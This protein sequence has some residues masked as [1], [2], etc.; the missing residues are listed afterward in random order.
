MYSRKKKGLVVMAS[1]A[2]T[3]SSIANSAFAYDKTYTVYMEG[4]AHIDTSWLWS[5]STTV[6][7]YVPDT[8]NKAVRL[9]DANSDYTFNSPAALHHLWTKQFYPDLFTK[10]KSKVSNGQWNLVGGQW[11]EPDLNMTSGESLVRQSLFGQRFFQKEFG[12]KSKVGWVPD[13]F[14]FSGQLPQILKKSGMDYFATTKLNWN[15]PNYFPYELFNWKGIDGTSLITYKPRVDYSSEV[16]IPEDIKYV[17]DAP[18]R[19]GIKK[20][21]LMY[22]DGDNGGGPDQTQIDIIHTYDKDPSMPSVKMWN[23]NSYFNNLTADDKSKITDTWDGEMYLENH[24]G[25]YTSQ[26][27]IKKNN[28]FGEVAAEEAEKFSSLANMFGTEGYPQTLIN[29]TWERILQNQFHD[30]LPGSGASGQVSEVQA[31]GEAALGTLNYII[32]NAISNISQKADTTG[33]GTPVIVYNPLSFSRKQPVETTI[34]F[35]SAPTSVRIFDNG[36]EI[37]SQV[38][39]ISGNSAK[40][41]FIVDGVPSVGYKVVHAVTNTGNYSGSGLTAINNVNA[42]K[43]LENQFYR[44]EINNSTGN[45][46]RIFKKSNNTEVLAG[47][48]NKLQILED[49]PKEWDAWNVDYDD[50]TATPLSN[51]GLHNGITLVE[52]GPVK[53]T[54]KVDKSYG[55]SSFSQFITLYNNIDKIDVRMSANWQE[56]HKMLKVAFPWNITGAKTADYEVA[57]GT[58]TR[59]NQRDTSFNKARFEVSAHKWADLSNNGYGVSLLNNC[60]YGY[61]TYQNTMRL[62]LLRSPIDPDSNCDKGSHEFTYSIYPHSGDW[63][64]AN[65]VYKGYELNYPVLAYQTTQ[66]SGNLGKSKSFMSVNVPNVILSVLKKAEDSN[67]YIVRMYETQGKS[68]TNATITLPNN[69]TSLYETNLLEENIGSRSF[70]GNSFTTPIGKYEIKTFKA[71]LGGITT[72]AYRENVVKFKTASA[73]SYVVNNEPKKAVDKTTA[74]N[75]SASNSGDK[76]LTINLDKEYTIKRWLVMH[77][78]QITPETSNYRQVWTGLHGMMLI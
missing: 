35:N 5:T 66:H 61:D 30:A 7:K 57:Y 45:I 74:S 34:T 77:A 12:V 42:D 28:R 21:M 26:A 71:N 65:T 51:L 59:S 1:L 14:G 24:R 64:T 63:K 72:N 73:S 23:G 29:D 78:R 38:L 62:S 46:K 75:W 49:T 31:N 69:I 6:N 50:M 33:N 27:L 70:N 48:G 55:K 52:S 44:V 25:T 76:W 40:V 36:T 8:Y 68:G 13:V 3:V 22:G 58:Q 19:L 16:N 15:D 53:S 9:M 54:F 39:S 20:G 10:I 32:S 4:N 17:L 47:E 37:P 43:I 67:D 56:T 11:V 41:V 2:L 60:K 18:Y